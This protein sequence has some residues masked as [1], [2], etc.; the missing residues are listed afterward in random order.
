MKRKK[1]REEN[2]EDR[3]EIKNRSEYRTELTEDISSYYDTNEHTTKKQ[4]QNIY[5]HIYGYF[6]GL[7]SA[8]W[9]VEDKEVDYVAL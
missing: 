9:Q 2:G 4:R 1:R 8:A 7:L 6:G 5:I 3:G